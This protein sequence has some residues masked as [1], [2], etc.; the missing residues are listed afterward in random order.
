MWYLE[1]GG[2]YCLRQLGHEQE[3]VHL[4]ERP[5][6]LRV[7]IDLQQALPITLLPAHTPNDYAYVADQC[8]P[9]P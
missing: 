6:Q 8:K 9:A 4:S 2:R 7:K 3:V 1:S 5:D